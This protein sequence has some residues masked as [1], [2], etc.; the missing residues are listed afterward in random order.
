A[1]FDIAQQLDTVAVWQPEVD[2]HHVQ[3]RSQ[4]SHVLQRFFGVRRIEALRIVLS[5]AFQQ[6]T[7]IFG[8]LAVIVDH[9]YVCA[10]NPSSLVLVLEPQLESLGS[11][12][13]GNQIPKTAPFSE[14]IKAISPPWA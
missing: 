9:Q 5:N 7:N 13:P 8:E 10:H 11:T 1:S 4:L 12:G 14:G 6:L 2:E 3:I